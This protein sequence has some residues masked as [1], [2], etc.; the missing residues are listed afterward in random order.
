MKIPNVSYGEDYALGLAISRHYRIGRIYS[1]IYTCRRWEDNSD[2]LLSIEALN[3]N[4]HYKDR[5][6]TIELMAR[7]R[8]NNSR[9]QQG[10]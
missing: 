6:R 5:L 3:R 4:N 7:I 2:A 9:T 1:P 8:L 10:S